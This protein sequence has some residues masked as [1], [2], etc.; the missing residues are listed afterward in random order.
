MFFTFFTHFQIAKTD[1]GIVNYYNNIDVLEFYYFIYKDII[2]LR[3][4]YNLKY[5]KNI[6]D[7]DEKHYSSDEEEE[8]TELK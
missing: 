6:N 3:E 2:E 4:E 7:Y 5:K 8:N 1:P